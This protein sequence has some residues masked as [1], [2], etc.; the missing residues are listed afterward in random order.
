MRSYIM[1]GVFEYYIAR[2]G[3]DMMSL[4]ESPR[5]VLVRNAIG[6]SGRFLSWLCSCGSDLAYL[7][8]CVC[9]CVCVFLARRVRLLSSCDNFPP[10]HVT[11]APH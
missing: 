3:H 9:M 11:P 1:F 4:A 7:F 10:Q 8:I 5:H 6:P 2:L